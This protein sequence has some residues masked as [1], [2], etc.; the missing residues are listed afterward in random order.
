MTTTY[1]INRLPTPVLRH[2]TPYEVF[3]QK[4]PSYQH[5]KVL[6]VL[7]LLLI[8]HGSKISCSLEEC[9]VFSLDIPKIKRVMCF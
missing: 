1:L 9:L 3:L 6:V 8:P 4:P 2:L 5:L 7:L